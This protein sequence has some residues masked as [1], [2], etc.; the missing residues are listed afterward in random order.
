MRLVALLLAAIMPVAYIPAVE[1][2]S[3][4]M[5]YTT[6]PDAGAIGSEVYVGIY[7][8]CEAPGT[9][10]DGESLADPTDDIMYHGCDPRV[11]PD[12]CA[13]WGPTDPFERDPYN[14]EFD[15]DPV[16]ITT[17]DVARFQPP[18]SELIIEPNGWG[19]VHRPLNVFTE[20]EVVTTQGEV[21]GRPVTIEWIPISF[22]VNYGDG[23]T[24]TYADP[25]ESWQESSPWSETE[26]S[27]V[28]T[29]TGDYVVTASIEYAAVVRIGGAVIPVNGTIS[30][31]TSPENVSIYWVK[32]RMVRGDCLEFPLDPGCDAP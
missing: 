5:C 24:Q 4:A 6:P 30:V 25:G 28:Y 2:P 22:T 31:E 13:W 15:G 10:E 18:A 29:E 14:E 3:A 19:I 11:D 23:T 7:T 20:A 26:T 21:L 9:G 32:T 12:D 27:H 16:V 1:L 8:E 17:R